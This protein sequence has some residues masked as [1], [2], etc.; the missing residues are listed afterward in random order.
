MDSLPL[1]RQ[2]PASLVKEASEQKD[3]APELIAEK[4]Q[5][6]HPSRHGIIRF[7]SEDA[8]LNLQVELVVILAKRASQSYSDL[9]ALYNLGST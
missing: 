4:E 7:N 8:I 1:E 5:E 6:L 3:K 9:I 2:E